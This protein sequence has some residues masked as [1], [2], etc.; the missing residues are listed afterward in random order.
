ML[1]YETRLTSKDAGDEG[2]I[3]LIGII[4][5]LFH[6]RSDIKFCQVKS[7]PLEM[8]W[9]NGTC[10]LLRTWINRL[11]GIF[12]IRSRYLYHHHWHCKDQSSSWLVS[13]PFY[14][15]DEQGSIQD[16]LDFQPKKAH[17][18][19]FNNQ[20]RWCSLNWNC[21]FLYQFLFFDISLLFYW[22]LFLLVIPFFIS[23]HF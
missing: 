11:D 9:T 23:G 19:I 14:F 13:P 20:H 4:I 22:W 6:I 17:F 21:R 18:H 8:A 12:F 10:A 16:T 7:I 2:D 3:F 15:H 5:F 1:C